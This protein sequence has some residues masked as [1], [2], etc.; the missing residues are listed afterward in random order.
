MNRAPWTS[1]SQRTAPW[2]S[3]VQ[4]SPPSGGSNWACAERYALAQGRT[5][6]Q[7][8]GRGDAFRHPHAHEGLMS[9]VPGSNPASVASVASTAPQAADE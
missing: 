8:W 6:A 4:R 7:L 3:G 2:T 9:A 1:A 5:H